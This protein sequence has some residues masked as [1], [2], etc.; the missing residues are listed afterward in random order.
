MAKSKAKASSG[1]VV[2]FE[3]HIY[4]V[5]ETQERPDVL[6][7]AERP[8]DSDTPYKAVSLLNREMVEMTAEEAVEAAQGLGAELIRTMTIPDDVR[9]NDAAVEEYKKKYNSEVMKSI[10]DLNE[11]LTDQMGDAT[12]FATPG[13]II[14]NPQG[15]P[16]L[17]NIELRAKESK[18][19]S[20]NTD[21]PSPG[22][23]AKS[24]NKE[25]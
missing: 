11:M 14:A 23:K 2:V 22:T 12:F 16:V 20:K 18:A 25:G 5:S 9:G 1:D 13:R 15:L 4:E 6:T 24:A 17:V 19:K 3:G 7:R 8:E 10:M 21:K